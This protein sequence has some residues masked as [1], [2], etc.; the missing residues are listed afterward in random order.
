MNCNS[1]KY[2]R[3]RYFMYKWAEPYNPLQNTSLFFDQ[4]SA[5]FAACKADYIENRTRQ[6]LKVYFYL[7]SG[8]V[9]SSVVREDNEKLQL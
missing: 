1:V 6:H 4:H 5:A 7:V 8:R 2:L 9:R 3:I